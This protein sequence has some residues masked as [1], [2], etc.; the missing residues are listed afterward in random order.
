MHYSDFFKY[1]QLLTKQ[2]KHIQHELKSTP[3]GKLIICKNNK[4]E[5]WYYSDGKTKT[6]LH[7]KDIDLA[8]KLAYK[9]YL[10]LLF[11]EL[12]KKEKLISKCLLTFASHSTPL[13]KY[14]S[15]NSSFTQL[16]SP[17]FT[18]SNTEFSN[19]ANEKY[20][21]NP[22]HPENLIHKTLSGHVVRSKSEAMIDSLLYS[23]K[24]PFRYECELVL[25]ESTLYPD[26][27][28]NHPHTG[29]IY[30]WEH[31]GM[32]ENPDYVDNVCKKL[33][34]YTSNNIFPHD[35]LIM[36]Y[37]TLNTPLS[38]NCIQGIIDY[39]FK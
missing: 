15:S 11:D 28:I 38:T 29:K 33:K 31:F 27:T 3:S 4:Y 16:I 17:Y 14:I 6:Y 39:Y 10:I 22:K 8:Q 20:N 18:P 35:Q 5:K 30:Y 7:K 26:F 9:K 21:T 23:N 1:H 36:S 19:W 24:I 12:S 32:L 2:L 13:E 37:E 34:L 25:K